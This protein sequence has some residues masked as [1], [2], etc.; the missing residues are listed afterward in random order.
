MLNSRNFSCSILCLL[1]LLAANGTKVNAA[2]EEGGGQ[3]PIF[4]NGTTVISP[5]KQLQKGGGGPKIEMGKWQ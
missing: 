5:T 4:A 2:D 1:L 3:G